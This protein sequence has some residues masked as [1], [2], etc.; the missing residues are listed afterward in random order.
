LRSQSNTAPTDHHL[1]F[2]R[3]ASCAAVSVEEQDRKVGCIENSLGEAAE[4]ELAKTTVPE[5]APD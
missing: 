1:H 5:S 4:D 3:A 2:H